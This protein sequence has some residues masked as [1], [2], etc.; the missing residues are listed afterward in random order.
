[1]VVKKKMETCTFNLVKY[2]RKY[3]LSGV[4]LWFV[5]QL[6]GCRLDT[7]MISAGSSQPDPLVFLSPSLVFFSANPWVFLCRPL[8]KHDPTLGKTRPDPRVLLF[9]PA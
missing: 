1:M 9:F 3:R 7:N 2:Q 5:T 8:E 6:S 4:R